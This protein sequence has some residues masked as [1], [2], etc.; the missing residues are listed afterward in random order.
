MEDQAVNLN[1]WVQ[2]QVQSTTLIDALRGRRSRRFGSGMQIGHGPFTYASQTA[3]HPLTEAEEAAL[4]FAAVGITGYALADLAYGTGQGGSM[5]GSLVGRTSASPDALT[6]VSLIVINDE[7]TYYIRRPQNLK[8]EQLAKLIEL[9]KSAD[10]PDALIEIYRLMRVKLRDGRTELPIVPE[11]MR[12]NFNINKWSL[13]AKGGTY[14]LPINDISA[15]L[16]NFLV[17]A[18]DPEMGLFLMDERNNYMPAGILKYAKWFGGHLYS[19][20]NAGR[21]GPYFA[22]ETGM[23]EAVAA[24]QGGVLQ[25]IGLMAQALGLGGFINFARGEFGWFQALNFRVKQMPG[26][27]YG[28]AA[29]WQVAMSKLFF[30]KLIANVPVGLEHN[31]EV[32][33]HAYSPPYYPN[34][35]AAVNAWVDHKFGTGGVYRNTEVTGWKDPSK[36]DSGI[37]RPDQRAIDAAA[38]LCEYMYRRYGRFPV[39]RSAF[40]TLVG[41]QATRVDV[42]FY[43]R[44]YRPEALTETQREHPL[45]P[46]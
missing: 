31:G 37:Q 25:N 11:V 14:F 24:E 27:K 28:G 34:M 20:P 23:A 40:A 44:F 4:V 7:A 43:D 3:P 42:E 15:P 39:Y 19:D 5:L 22:A 45:N 38:S 30:P 46:K 16:I 10:D 35:T 32:L 36:D 21:M 33:L 8:P 26:L 6:A 2:Q 12:L 41:Y 13:Y 29:W 17:E 9:S 1:E 18:F